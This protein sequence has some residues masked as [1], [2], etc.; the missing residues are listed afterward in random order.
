MLVSDPIVDEYLRVLNYPR[1]RKYPGITDEFIRDVSALL[2]HQTTRVEILTSLSVS[3]DPDDDKFLA[4]AVDGKADL[5]ISGD[6]P[7][8]LALNEIRGIPIIGAADAISRLEAKVTG[9]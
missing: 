3:K 9:A 2:I 7:H 1:I 8:L 4:A 6:K 5:L